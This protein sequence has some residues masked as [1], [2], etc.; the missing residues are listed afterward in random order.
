MTSAPSPARIMVAHGPAMLLVTSRTRMPAR[1]PVG[2]L[3]YTTACDHQDSGLPLD[4]TTQRQDFERGKRRGAGELGHDSG[5][6]REPSLRH[7]NLRIRYRDYFPAALLQLMQQAERIAR[8][9]HRDGGR[10]CL[11]ACVG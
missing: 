2:T 6:F 10:G 8:T 5:I 3:I 1:G 9:A 4:G 11:A 7:S